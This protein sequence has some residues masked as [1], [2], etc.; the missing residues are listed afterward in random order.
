MRCNYSLSSKAAGQNKLERLRS[1][2]FFQV[3]LIYDGK[4]KRAYCLASLIQRYS[5]VMG[6]A[7]TE[8]TSDKC[9]SLFC[10]GVSQ[11]KTKF[12]RFLSCWVRV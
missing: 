2:S 4:A 10:S 11:E 3:S 8:L 9:S 1:A 7:Q 6:K 12:I 5:H